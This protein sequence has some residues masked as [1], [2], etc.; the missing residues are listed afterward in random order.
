MVRLNSYTK[1]KVYRIILNKFSLF[2]NWWPTEEEE[3]YFS[4]IL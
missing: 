1:K 2:T 4:K 3:Y